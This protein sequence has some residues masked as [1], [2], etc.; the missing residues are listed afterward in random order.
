MTRTHNTAPS[1]KAQATK[2]RAAQKRTGV[3]YKASK[4]FATGPRIMKAYN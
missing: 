3:H 1:K 2:N 4:N